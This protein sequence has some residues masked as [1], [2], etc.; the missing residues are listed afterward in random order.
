MKSTAARSMFHFFALAV[1][2]APPRRQA[3]RLTEYATGSK[4]RLAPG[5]S[6]EVALH[7]NA[8]TG[9]NWEVAPGAEAVLVQKGETGFMADH[10][11]NGAGGTYTFTFQA[12]APGEA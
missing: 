12:V 4:V 2:L 3:S 1:A 10:G 7:G 6:V 8:A 9:F 11:V 5:E